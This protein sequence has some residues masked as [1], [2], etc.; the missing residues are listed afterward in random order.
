MLS[1]WHKEDVF[2]TRRARGWTG[3]VLLEYPK[4]WHYVGEAWSFSRTNWTLNLYFVADGTGVHG[5]DSV[6]SI[7]GKLIGVG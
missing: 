6:E 5:A 1:V 3:P 4:D 2:N 7:A